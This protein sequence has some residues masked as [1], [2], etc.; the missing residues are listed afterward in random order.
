MLIT[1]FDLSIWA[2][3]FVGHLILLAVLLG[4]KRH[5]H[6]PAFTSL[7]AFNVIRS[8]VLFAINQRNGASYFNA[9]WTLSGIDEALGFAIVYEGASIIFRPAGSWARDVRTA[10]WAT[11]AV[12]IAVAGI[13]TY[14]A[15]PATSSAVQTL[16]L[17][18]KFLASTLQ[19]EL[20][21]GMMGLSA[22]VGLPWRSHVAHI[23]QGLG[24]YAAFCVIADTA[25]TCYGIHQ[26]S[27]LFTQVSHARIIVYLACLSYWIIMLSRKHAPKKDMPEH[28]REQLGKLQEQLDADLIRVQAFK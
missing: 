18:G 1:G 5:I 7:I 23:F 8:V 27:S 3:S 17:K 14:I 6:L 12:S 2:A 28:M 24:V 9:Y 20:F 13:L 25:L 26:D 21:V 19:A 11:L 10:L 22:R 4:R 16:I 15:D